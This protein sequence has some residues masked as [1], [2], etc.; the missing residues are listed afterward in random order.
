M[1]SCCAST[2]SYQLHRSVLSISYQRRCAKLSFKVGGGCYLLSTPSGLACR[3]AWDWACRCA[4]DLQESCQW[5][6]YQHCFA[7]T[8]QATLINAAVHLSTV[9]YQ[10]PC[11]FILSTP[12]CIYESCQGDSYQ[13]RCASTSDSYQRLCAFAVS[14]QLP[15][16]V[17]LI[18]TPLCI[19]GLLSIPLISKIFKYVWRLN[20]AGLTLLTTAFRGGCI[21]SKL[22]HAPGVGDRMRS[23]T[24]LQE[25]SFSCFLFV[26]SY[27]AI[28]SLPNLT[29]AIMSRP[30]KC[31]DTRLLGY[32]GMPSYGAAAQELQN[33]AATY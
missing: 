5:S 29:T 10:S 1:Q 4:G 9:S 13:R 17:T 16:S 11:K 14:Y 20:V 28:A 19:Y 23:Y 24:S 18:S 8:E 3:C 6:S 31:V 7:S 12:L 32:Q 21:P 25:P 33:N 22:S 2:V 27:S 30:I 26:S 15:C